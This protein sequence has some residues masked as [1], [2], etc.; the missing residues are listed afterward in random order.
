MKR[1]LKNKKGFTLIELLA[2]I[3]ILG[4][5][6]IV[7]IPA[8]GS[9]T[10]NA[11]KNTYESNARALASGLRRELLIGATDG[12]AT[13]WDP[14]PTSGPRSYNIIDSTGVSA[15]N[16]EQGGSESPYGSPYDVTSKIRITASYSS[17]Q[18]VEY[19]YEICILD[20]LGNGTVDSDGDPV[21]VDENDLS[22]A[23]FGKATAGE[24][25][26]CP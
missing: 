26:V 14:L 2:V 20:N 21:Y 3:V 19:K 9:I 11:R 17:A 6:M 1:M 4:I 23:S 7:A 24:A 8:I 15:V 18:I 25:A 13:N 12:S 5:L 16:L 22:T 10:E